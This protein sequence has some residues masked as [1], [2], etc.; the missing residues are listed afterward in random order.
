M[1]RAGILEPR[2][3][4]SAALNPRLW[5]LLARRQVPKRYL[6]PGPSELALDLPLSAKPKGLVSP[7][8]QGA[9][10]FTPLLHTRPPRCLRGLCLSP[11][12]FSGWATKLARMIQLRRTGTHEGNSA[13]DRS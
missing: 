3:A 12:L 10:S 5:R 7:Q 6:F 11:R 2:P 4:R 1:Y 9:G 13:V 8:I